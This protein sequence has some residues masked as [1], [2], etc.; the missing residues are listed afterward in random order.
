MPLNSSTSPI[1]SADILTQA[2]PYIQKY[3]HQT[4]VIKF[5]GNAM[6]DT[7]LSNAFAHDVTLMRQSGV[8]TIIV[9]GG[10]PQIGN[11]LERLGIES[12]FKNGLRVTNHATME[13]AEMVLV[14]KINKEI[15]SAIN[16]SGG[17]AV[18]LCGKDGDMI[19]AERLTTK[20][21]GQDNKIS[22]EIDM[23][24][25]GEPVVLNP[26]LLNHLMDKDF[27]PVVAPV[28]KGKDGNTYNINA[29]IFAGFIASS[30]KAKRLLFLTDVPG[31][32]GK[33]D[34]LIS[35][36]TIGE[37]RDLISDGTISGGMIPKVET[38]VD[39]IQN[40]VEGVAILNGKVPHAVILE[41]F[42][43]SGA[44]TL[45]VPND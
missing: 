44:G 41:L 5:G 31:V 3:E 26:T 37:S 18:G 17:C 40:G 13:V 34:E 11:M 2:L 9:H 19:T 6:G 27:I 29:D 16:Q 38:C 1:V 12:E 4:V 15:V 45:L 33:E 32:L 24:F 43:E 25:V 36:L 14:G 30:L 23:G 42:T 35:N 39:A 10:G 7:A 22:E 28:A 20:D 8:N 21:N